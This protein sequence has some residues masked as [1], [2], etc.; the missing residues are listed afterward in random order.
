MAAGRATHEARRSQLVPPRVGVSSC[1]L[2]DAV[3]WDGGHRRHD[4]VI[5]GLGPHVEWVPLCPEMEIGLG[6]PREPIQ[7]LRT[8]SGFE[9]FGVESKRDLTPLMNEWAARTVNDLD[10]LD[11]YVLKANSPS[12]GLT[13]AR[14]FETRNALDTNG[15]YTR[16]GR[17]L[18]A[19]ALIRRHPSLPIVEETDLDDAEIRT[20]FVERIFAMRR[21]RHL[22]SYEGGLGSMVEFVGRHRVQLLTRSEAARERVARAAQDGDGRALRLA[23]SMALAEPLGASAWSRAFGAMAD[24]L[25]DADAGGTLHAAAAD[26]RAD[27]LPRSLFRTAAESAGD[28]FLLGQ[29]VLTPDAGETAALA[30]H[31]G[32]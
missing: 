19:D 21:L 5:G 10:D 30:P 28:T 15:D 25:E 27:H 26:A 32:D 2:G 31:A 13:G 18:F 14:V 8:V 7:L 1:L 22:L 23:L 17:G 16:T 4:V 9:L 12:C 24:R 3:R 11:G 20:G 6:V 29:T